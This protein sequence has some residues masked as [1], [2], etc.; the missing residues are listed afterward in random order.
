MVGFDLDGTLVDSNLDLAPAIN[1]ALSLA[2]RGPIDPDATRQLIGGG[3]RLMLERAFTIT[4]GM[5]PESEF[6][7]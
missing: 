2:G 5:P 1:H 4:G 7:G 6:D 3:S